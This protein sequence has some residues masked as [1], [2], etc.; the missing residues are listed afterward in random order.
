[1][2]EEA[3][4]TEMAAAGGAAS[5]SNGTAA[6]PL[7]ATAGG[8]ATSSSRSLSSGR[9][10]PASAV[11]RRVAK[12]VMAQLSVIKSMRAASFPHTKND[13][14][15]LRMRTKLLYSAPSFS[16]L[17]LTMLIS[18]HA[19]IF[20]ESIG[21][22]LSFLAFYTALGRSF[23]VM[24]DPAMG[25]WSDATRT[26]FGRR[27]PY[28]AF[29]AIG[30]AVMFVLFMSPPASLGDKGTANWFGVFY[31]LFYLFDTIANIP[32][33]AWGPELSDHSRERESVYFIRGLFDKAGVLAGA[34]GPAVVG[35]ILGNSADAGT[36]DA[37]D[38]DGDA[39][40]E[41]REVYTIVAVF[42]AGYYLLTVYPL[43][44]LLKERHA[45]Q[46]DRP[47]PLVPSILRSFKNHA[48]RPLLVAWT[49]DFFA[50][51]LISAMVPFFV[52][53]VI[54]PEN[55][56]RVLAIGLGF[57]FVASAA[58]SPAWK[59]LSSKYGKRNVWLAYNLLNSVTNFGFIVVGENDVT[60]FYVLAL[61][62]GIPVG[63]QFLIDAILSDVIDYDEFLNGTRNEGSFTVFS[64]F[65]PKVI[66]IPAS[67]IPLAIIAA[68]GFRQTENG[69]E[70]P[71]TD[72][73]KNTIRAIFVIIP[74]VATLASYFIKLRY[75]LR[76]EE[77]VAKVA[78]G[79]VTHEAGKPA[80]D[81][82]TKRDG[83]TILK[84][85]EEE[86]HV[87]WLLDNFN[88]NTLQGFLKGKH[89]RYLALTVRAQMVTA[90]CFF[91]G[92]V[93]VIVFTFP[94]LD[95]ESLAWVPAFCSIL[96]GISMCLAGV[97]Y[98]RLQAAIELEG[99]DVPV[100]LVERIMAHKI[101]GQRGGNYNPDLIGHEELAALKQEDE[102]IQTEL[103]V[104]ADED[105][106]S[107]EELSER[108]AMADAA[109]E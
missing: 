87:A 81:P 49:L 74:S 100:E 71:Q 85:N 12:R 73:V 109:N 48:F 27:R 26:R 36:A 2:S 106:V 16:L 28:I 57:L 46:E 108:S 80:Y 63:G 105:A 68:A 8:A 76:T 86:Q 98:L 47:V 25:W 102:R 79:I 82:V 75:P 41:D 72:A 60:L 50:L 9:G 54:K 30:Y 103:S 107:L 65:L 58:A 96:S 55:P 14:G 4:S 95:D 43:V 7:G 5:S 99:M 70:Q 39:T 91:V 51:A 1:M 19:I 104:A 67:A 13:E 93:I 40:A 22:S 92:F 21:A 90:I 56:D 24:S 83:I 29:G 89:P 20:Y 10:G 6:V 32:L 94:W 34:A 23:D 97:S 101:R 35:A 61:I 84:L 11:F 88:W 66:S 52:K 15:Q 42:F 44:F 45:S 31:I 3:S 69:V 37:D 17:S 59:W 18:I 53:F 38:T 64:T 33:L 62:N 77:D 78:E